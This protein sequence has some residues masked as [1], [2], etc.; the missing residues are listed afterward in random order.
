MKCKVCGK[1]T[2]RSIGSK[3]VDCYINDNL[4][5]KVTEDPWVYARNFGAKRTKTESTIDKELAFKVIQGKYELNADE[6][7]LRIGETTV[8]LTVEALDELA[9]KTGILL[10]KWLIYGDATQIDETWT[11]IA[12]A[13]FSGELGTSAKASTARQR[14]KR[15]VICV[16]TQNYLDLDDVKRVREKLREIGFAK[17]LCYKPDIYTYLNIYSGTTTLTPCRYRE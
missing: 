17:T 13:V 6:S 16:Y 15:H 2:V 8:P 3:C 4:P 11:K 5:T 7:T 12:K 1:R 10:G 14:Q 9:T